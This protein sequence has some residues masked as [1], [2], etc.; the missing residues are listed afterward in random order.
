MIELLIVMAIISLMALVAAPRIS[1]F[2]GNERRES[3]LLAA[4]IAAA[5]DNAL[6]NG[7]T[8]YLC[9]TLSPDESNTDLFKEKNFVPNS[10]AVYVLEEMKLVENSHRILKKKSFSGSF[11]IKSV[12]LEGAEAINRGDVTIPF[13]SDGSSESFTLEVSTGEK[14]RYFKKNK[15]S[16][17]LVELDEI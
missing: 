10:V 8:N 16:R 7:R 14:N 6:V 13:Y 12:C 17:I 11:L 5:S 1:A 9:I 4:Y 15:N 2:L 3:G